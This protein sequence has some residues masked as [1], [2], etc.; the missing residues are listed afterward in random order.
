MSAC[1]SA[2]TRCC[3]ASCAAN[4]ATPARP[5]RPRTAGP[6]LDAFYEHHDVVGG[7][8]FD[9]E[10][11]RSLHQRATY[12]LSVVQAGIDQPDRRSSLHPVV[13]RQRFAPSSSPTSRSTAARRCIVT[14]QATRPTGTWRTAD[15]R[16][17]HRVTA[18]ADWNGE[19]ATLDDR[20]SADQVERIAR[21]RRRRGPA[22][23]ALASRSRRQ[24]ARASN[25]TTA[26]ARR[27][28]RAGRRSSTLRQGTR[29][30]RR[31][32][33]CTRRRDS[34]SRNRRCFRASARR[35]TSQGNPDLEPE[36][37]R[38]AEAGLEQRLAS[39]RAKVEPTWFD[40]RYRDIIGLHS[41]AGSFH[42][43][44]LQ[45]RPDHA[46][47]APNSRESWRRIPRCGSARATP[48]STPRFW[49]ARRASALCS[50]S[51]SGR[52]G[53]RATRD[54]CRDRGRGSASRQTSRA[55]S[56]AASSTATSHRST[57]AIVENDGRTTWDARLGY[58]VTSRMTGLLAI[59]NLTGDRDYQEPLGY[60]ALRRRSAPVSASVSE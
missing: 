37:S 42:V 24:P 57:P 16:G 54:S 20:L 1:R 11:N 13:R 52:S 32:A 56:S 9:Q 28:F 25:T 10:L 48:S 39:D 2:R 38:A 53:G 6:D 18:L 4:S 21:Q 51:A 8:T 49:R 58:R 40:N 23:D 22:P 44:V 15:V 33:R 45:H 55:S 5:G 31:H 3:A 30:L 47:A 27:S 17:D 59:D 34:A 36:R 14:T 50:R 7:V 43:R 12:S 19:R 46:R 60:Q 26:L 29:A 35:P 41:T